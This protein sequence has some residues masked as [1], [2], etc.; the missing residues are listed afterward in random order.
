MHFGI[1]IFFE[2]VFGNVG[3]N[4]SAKSQISCLHL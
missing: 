4:L 3:Y 1:C 2:F